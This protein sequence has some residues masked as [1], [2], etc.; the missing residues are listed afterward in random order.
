MLNAHILY[1]LKNLIQTGDY[2]YHVGDWI[3]DAATQMKTKVL[4]ATRTVKTQ[5]ASAAPA[6][7]AEIANKKSLWTTWER[8]PSWSFC[9][10]LSRR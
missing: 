9:S 7:K 4:A 6:G 2:L 8:C 5:A 3:E 10:Q 1:E